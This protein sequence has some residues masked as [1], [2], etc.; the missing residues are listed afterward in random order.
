MLGGYE[1]PVARDGKRSV[2]AITDTGDFN[3]TLSDT[4]RLRK[5][6]VAT[7]GFS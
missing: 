7:G 1:V 2:G 4:R 6:Q 3:V 5:G